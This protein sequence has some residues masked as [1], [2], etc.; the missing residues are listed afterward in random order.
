MGG[1]VSVGVLGF[2]DEEEDATLFVSVVETVLTEILLAPVVVM[3]DLVSS[4]GVDADAESVG[5]LRRTDELLD[6][7]PPSGELVA[8]E[9]NISSVFLINN[10]LFN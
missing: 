1:I 2:I 7:R 3:V 9:F 8:G 4:E 6:G 5:R 10:G